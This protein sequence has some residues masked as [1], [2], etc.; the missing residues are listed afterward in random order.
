MKYPA[1]FTALLATAAAAQQPMIA[2]APAPQAASAIPNGDQWL[3]G[4]AEGSVATLQTYKALTTYAL[5]AARHRPKA[6][7]ILAQDSSPVSSSSLAFVPCGAKPLAVVF[8]ADETLIWNIPPRRDNMLHNGGSFDRTTWQSWERTGAGHATA[9]PGVIEA[10]RALRA[11]GIT[12]IVNTN[13]SA[14]TAEGTVATL[15]AA[16]IGDYVHG[17]TLFLQGDDQLGGSKD[18]RRAAIAAHYCVIAM[19]GDQLGDFSNAFNDP[20]LAPAERRGAA[21]S[22]PAAALWGRGWFLLPNPSYGPW[23][24]KLKFEDVYGTDPWAPGVQ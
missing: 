11:A 10:L 3:Y 12:P 21:T 19:T 4:S 16:G 13:R 17:K 9:M 5:A 7:V 6:S 22:G 23:A 20:K 8:D 14:A 15:K 24:G 18:G 2:P 1:M